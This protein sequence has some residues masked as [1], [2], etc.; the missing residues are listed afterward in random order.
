MSPRTA[1]AALVVAATL[2]G[3]AGARVTGT[4]VA[5]EAQ[6]LRLSRDLV[7]VALD[8]EVRAKLQ[9]QLALFV[10]QSIGRSVQTQLNR[11]L[12]DVEWRILERI[13]T[14]FTDE[15]L[16]PS[17]MEQVYAAVYANL[18]DENELRELIRFHGTS[19]GRKSVRLQGQIGQD[20]LEAMARV[21]DKSPARATLVT[22]LR[23]EFPVLGPAES[24]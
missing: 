6:R 21:V 15:A 3:A 12:L 23:R 19:A 10:T 8:D 2:I 18:F 22:E 17:Q 1:L 4:A 16:P 5:D 13:A 24:P 9:Q 14:R 11:R 20:A 7:T